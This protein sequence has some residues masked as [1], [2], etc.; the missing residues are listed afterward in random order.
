MLC[1]YSLFIS[2]TPWV[3]KDGLASTILSIVAHVRRVCLNDFN[4]GDVKLPPVRPGRDT[5]NSFE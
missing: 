4:L 1:F 3:E 2:L 5:G